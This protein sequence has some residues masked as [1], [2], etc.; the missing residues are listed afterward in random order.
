MLWRDSRGRGPR[1]L[2]PLHPPRHRALARHRRGRRDR[3]PVPRLALRRRR[4]VHARSRSSPTRPACPAKARARRV[5]VRR[6]LRDDLGRARGAAL[7]AAR[8]AGARGP[9]GGRHCGPYEWALRRVAP[10]R[11][12]HRLRPLPVRASRACSATRSGRSSPTTRSR[13]DGHVLHY[14]IVRPEAPD[15]EEFPVFGNEVVE[16]P[17]RRSRYELHLPYTIVL[18]LG[19]GGEAGM[20]Y[21]FASQPA[22]PDRL[23]AAFS[24]SAATTTSSSPT[25]CCRTSRT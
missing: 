22:G 13:T 1:V 24:R 12:L 6:A 5:H 14:E 18:R 15:N 16:A 19:W 2:R 23:H 21:F 10:G 7:G 8:R 11:E 20:V 17:E 25:R 3:L 9:P 4:R